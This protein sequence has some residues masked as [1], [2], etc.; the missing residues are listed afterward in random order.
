VR[1]R[2]S[3][4]A[5]F[6][7]P[8]DQ[9]RLHLYMS[10]RRTQEL[11]ATLRKGGHAGTAAAR[12]SE[13][14]VRGLAA[15]VDGNVTGRVRIVHEALQPREARG[16]GLRKVP[17]E[18]L[19]G[20]TAKVA[21]WALAGLSTFLGGSAARFIAAADDAQDGVTV[22]LTIPNPPGLAAIRQVIAAAP[23]APGAANGSTAPAVRVDVVPGYKHG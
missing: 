19:H 13:L 15:A 9:V 6:D 3:L 10:E 20:F 5:I 2:T 7:F 12:I 17:P 21:E 11:A 23:G 14:I 4:Q 16:P 1:H 18:M 22:I 8:G